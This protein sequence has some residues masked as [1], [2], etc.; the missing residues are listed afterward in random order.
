MQNRI[1]YAGI[2]ISLFVWNNLFSKEDETKINLETFQIYAITSS[3]E[4][5]INL[6]SISDKTDFYFQR[7]KDYINYFSLSFLD[8]KNRLRKIITFSEDP[9]IAREVS[10]YNEKG[11]IVSTYFNKKTHAGVSGY[12]KIYF[13]KGK[14]KTSE[15]YSDSCNPQ[16]VEV[17]MLPSDIYRCK[18]QI[19]DPMLFEIPSLSKKNLYKFEKN[20]NYFEARN[21]ITKDW[22]FINS[23]NVKIRSKPGKQSKALDTL[24]ILSIVQILEVDKTENINP[25]GSYHWYKIAYHNPYFDEKEKIGYIFGAFLEP[26]HQLQLK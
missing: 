9:D 21:L 4:K 24:E 11:E 17:D 12:G 7:D 18:D 16:A 25:W 3:N 14:V 23:T 13:Q 22:T 6:A 5:M 8:T 10:F 1:F 26:I 19:P 20:K 15:I 2:I